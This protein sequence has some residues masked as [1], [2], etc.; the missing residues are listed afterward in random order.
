MTPL[1]KPR[2]FLATDLPEETT[3]PPTRRPAGWGGLRR[4]WESGQ[5]WLELVRNLAVRDVE[6]RYKHSLLGLYW[7]IIN[8][9]F[10]AAIFSF[11]F[12]TVFHASNK[13]IPYIVFLLTGLTFWNFFGN[14][15]NSGAVSITGNAALLAK[16]YFPRVVLPTAA[17]LARLIDFLFSCVVLAVFIGL[18]RVP[19]HWS[20][21]WLVPL[22]GLQLV[23]T[24]GIAYLV[25]AANVLY[26]DVTQLLGLVLLAW[27]YFSPVMYPINGVANW[28][29]AVL[30]LNPMGAILQAERDVLFTGYLTHPAALAS[31]VV[32]SGFLFLGGLTTFKRV[33]PLFSEVL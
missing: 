19:I 6:T 4:R 11:V 31:A 21:L 20:T 3:P 5:V 10:T 7:A 30:L 22:L 8:P 15:V 33:E 16:I 25:A 29:Q 9:L 12:G 1:T 2:T 27:M 24:L 14:S 26:R 17:V 13:P 18:Y 32:W 28:I 23:F